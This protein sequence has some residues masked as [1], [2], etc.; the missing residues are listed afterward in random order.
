[1]TGNKEDHALKGMGDPE[2]VN[3]LIYLTKRNTHK[4][5]ISMDEAME[6]EDTK[7]EII[8]RLENLRRALFY[9]R[10]ASSEV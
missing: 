9:V 7:N 4:K 6:M 8:Y 5:E 1:M 10:K 2:L 3:R